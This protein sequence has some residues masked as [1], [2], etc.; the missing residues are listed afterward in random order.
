MEQLLLHQLLLRVS[1]STWKAEP[2]RCPTAAGQ[3]PECGPAGVPC[4]GRRVGRCRQIDAPNWRL[5]QR[6][7]GDEPAG[8]AQQKVLGNFWQRVS[9]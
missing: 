7:G 9:S 5:L 8:S 4:Y 3:L 1:C 2:A 6:F